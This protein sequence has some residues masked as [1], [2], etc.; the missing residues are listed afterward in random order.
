MCALKNQH[1]KYLARNF[2]TCLTVD[3]WNQ[4]PKIVATNR[5]AKRQIER[6]TVHVYCIE[7]LR[8]TKTLL[9]L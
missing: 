4:D 6:Q 8:A 7:L 2:Q 9:K 5:Q 1:I 3:P